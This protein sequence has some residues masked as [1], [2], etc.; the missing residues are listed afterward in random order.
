MKPTRCSRH[1]MM[2]SPGLPLWRLDHEQEDRLMRLSS[3]IASWMSLPLV[4]SLASAGCVAGPAADGAERGDE[5]TASAAEACEAVPLDAFLAE[6]GCALC[7][8]V[9][10]IDDLWPLCVSVCSF[11]S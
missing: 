4:L 7:P 11:D 3:K 8:A 5:S 1:R 9:T 6:G 10:P 2:V